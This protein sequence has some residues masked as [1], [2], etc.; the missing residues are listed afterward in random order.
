[1]TFRTNLAAAALLWV[2][3][4]GTAAAHVD[5]GGAGSFVS[6]FTHPILG[7][8]HVAA[9]VASGLWAAVLGRPA[10]WI[11]PVVF[12]L[13]MALAAT[14]GVI[15]ANIRH[16]A[17]FPPAEND[18]FDEHKAFIHAA[19]ARVACSQCGKTRQVTVPWAR[20]GS[21]FTQLFDA[22]AIGLVREMPVMGNA[23]PPATVPQAR[24]NA[25]DPLERHPER[26][27][28]PTVQRRRRGH[29]WPDPGRQDLRPRLSHDPELHQQDLPRLRLAQ[30]S[31]SIAELHNIWYGRQPTRARAILTQ[32]AKG[33]EFR[34]RRW[35]YCARRLVAGGRASCKRFR[36]HLAWR[37]SEGLS[38]RP[39]E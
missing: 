34:R 15:G 37:P 31:A 7:W 27:R 20:S 19:V 24:Q 25:L 1:M 11:L 38:E 21:G 17:R 2:A 18:G 36:A 22:F 26:V 23:I 35:Q 39:A 32:I 4:A 29:G 30:A 9:M 3:L 8:D 6:G 13:V 33:P 5:H 12:P 14:A 28:R 16:A 10:I